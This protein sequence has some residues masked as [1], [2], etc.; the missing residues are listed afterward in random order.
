MIRNANPRA[1][2]DPELLVVLLS[3]FRLS[4]AMVVPRGFTIHVLLHQ[5]AAPRDICQAYLQ[6]RCVGLWSL[7]YPI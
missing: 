1:G 3:T 4:R 7:I 5:T 2:A 6:A